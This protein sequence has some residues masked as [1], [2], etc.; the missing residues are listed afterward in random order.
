MNWVHHISYND[1]KVSLHIGMSIDEFV[2]VNLLFKLKNI[3][4]FN[5]FE[6]QT[7]TSGENN[8]RGGIQWS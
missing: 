3:Y 7:V 8:Y 1:R 5:L 6:I 4:S 2:I